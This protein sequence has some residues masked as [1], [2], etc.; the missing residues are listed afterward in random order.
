MRPHYYKGGN[1]FEFHFLETQMMSI[2]MHAHAHIC[3]CPSK[4]GMLG[5]WWKGEFNSLA[6]YCKSR[7]VHPFWPQSWSEAQIKKLRLERLKRGYG[8]CNPHLEAGPLED[9]TL[10][11]CSVLQDQAWH[12]L[13]PSGTQQMLALLL[14]SFYKLRENCCTFTWKIIKTIFKTIT[15]GLN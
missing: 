11:D 10:E 2:L 1:C 4:G 6:T 13:S 9:W 7:L 14:I 8:P 15:G 12:A 5:W 3:L